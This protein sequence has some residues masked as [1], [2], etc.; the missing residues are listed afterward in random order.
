MISVLPTCG[1]V[2]KRK[3][4]CLSETQSPHWKME[5]TV[6]ST[7]AGWLGKLSRA[8]KLHLTSVEQQAAFHMEMLLRPSTSSR[9]ADKSKGYK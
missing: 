7:S 5:N 2:A 1:H 8:A 4:P 3:Q 6:S 9:L